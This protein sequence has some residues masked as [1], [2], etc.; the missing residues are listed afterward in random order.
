VSRSTAQRWWSRLGFGSVPGDPEESRAFLQKR[1]AF[2]LG[3]ACLLW[4]VLTIMVIIGTRIEPQMGH[5][6]TPLYM[7]PEAINDASNVDGRTDIYAVG[8]VAHHLLT[9]QRVFDGTSAV[10]VCGHHL[11]SPVVPP[12]ARAG[13]TMPEGLERLV[14]DCLEKD[15][16]KRVQSAAVLLDRL[17][18]CGVGPWSADEARRWWKDDAAA[19]SSEESALAASPAQTTINVDLEGRR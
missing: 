11:F 15:R 16:D 12:S 5:R 17:E 10:Q 9:G 3:L 2:Y 13:R 4:S 19:I 14:L 7:S 1:V 18:E 6:V 8:A